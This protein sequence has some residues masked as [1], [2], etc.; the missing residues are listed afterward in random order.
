M[1]GSRT[2]SRP[3]VSYSDFHESPF[4]SEPLSSETCL[5]LHGGGLSM[6]HGRMLLLLP[7]TSSPPRRTSPSELILRTLRTIHRSYTS[8]P[9]EAHNG[10]HLLQI[11]YS[12]F[13]TGR[14]QLAHTFLNTNPTAASESFRQFS[15]HGRAF[16]EQ[17]I[18]DGLHVGLPVWLTGKYQSYSRHC[19]EA[20][21]YA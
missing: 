15:T 12:H 17:C 5:A 16:S 3:S 18:R 14:R 9:K 21:D 20:K 13:A 4:A 8:L 7:L 2:C 1:P 10:K 11:A 19:D 6:F